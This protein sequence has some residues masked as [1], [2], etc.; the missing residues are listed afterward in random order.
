[1]MDNERKTTMAKSINWYRNVSYNAPSK[2]SFH[3]M[4]RARLRKLALALNLAPGSYDIRSNKGGIAVSGEI[5][6][7]TDSVYVQVSQPYAATFDSGILIRTCKGRRD[8]TGGPNHFAPL[9]SLDDIESLA[10]RVRS[11]A[12]FCSAQNATCES[13]RN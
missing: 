8:Y 1:M 9:S 12:P 10:R 13:Y 6:L 5:T 7:H 3:S 2:D 11:V 4:A